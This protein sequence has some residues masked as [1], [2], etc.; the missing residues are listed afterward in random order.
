[1]NSANHN[2]FFFF[3]FC[4]VYKRVWVVLILVDSRLSIVLNHRCFGRTF[5]CC[6]SIWTLTAI[7]RSAFSSMHIIC[8]YHW[9]R[10]ALDPVV[11]VSK[12]ISLRSWLLLAGNIEPRCLNHSA[13]VKSL[14]LTYQYNWA[15]W[16]RFFFGFRPCWAEQRS[17]SLINADMK[18]PWYILYTSNFT[19][20][21]AIEQLKPAHN[22]L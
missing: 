12:A 3:R 4:S 10:P 21:M 11:L 5:S 14:A 7:F 13:L 16:S 9:R 15:Q 2:F 20:Q 1:M 17:A 22:L 8:P 6:P 19:L 18:R